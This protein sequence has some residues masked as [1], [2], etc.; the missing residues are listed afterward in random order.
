MKQLPPS[1]IKSFRFG[2][3][4]LWIISCALILYLLVFWTPPGS[5]IWYCLISPFKINAN[6]IPVYPNAQNI[7]REEP[8]MVSILE[9]TTSDDPEIVWK[10]YVDVMWRK[11]GFREYPLQQG[12][13]RLVVAKCNSYDFYMTSTQFD[14]NTYNITLQLEVVPYH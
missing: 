2:I 11:W 7:T 14:S 6:D 12:D 4:G 9:F 10:Y 1:K 5:F 8:P 3:V 13:K